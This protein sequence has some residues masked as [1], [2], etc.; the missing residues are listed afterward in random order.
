MGWLVM[1]TL[2]RVVGEV[3]R[4]PGMRGSSAIVNI[5]LMVHNGAWMEGMEWQVPCL[6]STR[7]WSNHGYKDRYQ[8][9]VAEQIFF[10][11][12]DNERLRVI[13]HQVKAKCAT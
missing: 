12:R 7:R 2:S 5:L 11:E 10:L 1:K 6:R 4:V 13:N 3:L 8:K 9:G